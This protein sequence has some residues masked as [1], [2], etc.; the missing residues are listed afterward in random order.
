LQFWFCLHSCLIAILFVCLSVFN[1]VRLSVNLSIFLLV[2]H[3]LSCLFV[4]RCVCLFLCCPACLSACHPAWFLSG[5]CL[6]PAWYIFPSVCQRKGD[7]ITWGVPIFFFFI[8]NGANFA[9]PLLWVP[10]TRP[11]RKN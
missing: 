7:F 6:V 10:K 9:Q 4:C 3:L 1:P 11:Q 2:C 8:Q 5:S